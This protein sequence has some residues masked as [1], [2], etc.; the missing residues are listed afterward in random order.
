MTNEEKVQQAETLRE[1]LERELPYHQFQ[2]IEDFLGASKEA[3]LRELAHAR[4]VIIS[5][6][7]TAVRKGELVKQLEHRIAQLRERVWMY[8][9]ALKDA[10]SC[11][12]G[13]RNAGEYAA[14]ALKAATLCVAPVTPEVP[15]GP[16][17][18]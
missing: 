18:D 9:Y 5:Q 16:E 1:R 3:L 13:L 4:A 2:E 11:I 7:E 8:R 17:T 12:K 14:K 15:R 10:N 6:N